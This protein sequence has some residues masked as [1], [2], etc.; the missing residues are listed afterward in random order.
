MHAPGPHRNAATRGPVRL[1]TNRTGSGRSASG[2]SQPLGLTPTVRSLPVSATLRMN[3]LVA[4]RTAAGQETIHLGFGEASFPL[5]P[6]LREALAAG[7][8]STAYPPVLGFPALRAAVAGYLE[9][10]RGLQV[11]AEQVGIGPGSK[12]MIYALL[13]VLEGDVLLPAPSWVSYAPQARLLGKR[14]LPV[15]ADPANHLRLSPDALRGAM[16]R[17]R[18]AGADPRIL[19]AN[20]PSNPTGGMLAEEDVATLTDWARE[21]RITIIS[22]EIYAELAH[23]W[24][25]HVSPAR[26]YPEGTIV[27][28][29]I[30]KAFSAG[31]WRLGYAVVPA[32][33]AGQQVLSAARAVASEIW[34][35]ASGPMQVAATAA[36]R[37]DPETERYVRRSA[38]LHAFVTGRLRA[39]LVLQGVLCPRPAGGF[40]LYPDF[41]PWREALSARGIGTGMA[42]ARHLLDDFGV[43][44]LPASEFGEPPEALRLRLATSKLFE[45]EGAVSAQA[46]EAWLW[47]LL[48]AADAL[49]DDPGAAMLPDTLRLPA[50]ERAVQRLGDFIQVLGAP[51]RE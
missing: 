48:A 5:L 39:A 41:A 4:A 27:T 46:R 38:R 31:G 51:T 19:V 2:R 47:S 24:R 30:S 44:T 29:S 9:R 45:P 12:P 23:G 43:A 1:R 42:L 33:P 6:Q 13:Q 16:A 15:P 32:G 20:T 34:S 10:T 3:E 25:P 14:I 35:G 11:A 22:D 36:Y 40:Y 50:L 49:G 17:A 21:Q 37:P 26:L 8:S 28:G 7:A 18:H